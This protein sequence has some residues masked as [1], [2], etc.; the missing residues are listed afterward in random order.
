MDS[1][2]ILR[3]RMRGQ[4]ISETAFVQPAEVVAW[5]GAVQAQDFAAAKWALALR[6][7]GLTDAA[8]EQALAD[9]TIL[10]THVLRPTWHFVTPAD[11]RWLLALTAPRVH[12]ANAYQYRKLGLDDEVFVRSNDALARAL[13][14]SRQL[15]RTELEAALRR[16]GVDT[17]EPLRFIYLIMR[18]ELDGIVCSGGRRGK[19][20]TY[21]LLDER[22]PQAK[23]LDRDEGLAEL[24]RRYFV[25]RGPAT[26][27]DFAWWSGLSMADARAGLELVKPQLESM[28]LGGQTYWFA[29]PPALPASAS[30]AAHLLPNY[31]EYMV[32]YTDRSLLVDEAQV[33]VLNAAAG[34][35]L[36]NLVVV[37][38]K[39]VGAWKR[40]VKKAAVLVETVP[41]A[42]LAEADRQ[43]V[44]AAAE[45]Y[46]AFLQLPVELA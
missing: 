32:G 16:V 43:A 26:V 14:G 3:Q 15:T 25:S 8:V 2:D 41:F 34:A 36:Q 13:Q 33:N 18:A 12:A 28:D 21:A 4:A 20:F 40:T 27:Q 23:R 5:L 10:R 7:K 24:A 19:Q 45:R 22:A 37:D 1:M 46:G 30:P 17:G 42:P 11:I 44:A 39:A 9:G 6:A 31:D 38:G 35:L 29:A